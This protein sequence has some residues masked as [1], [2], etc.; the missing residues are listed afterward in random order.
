MVVA[1]VAVFN[2]D[3]VLVLVVL[4]AVVMVEIIRLADQEL[5]TLV[6]AEVVQEHLLLV[7]LVVQVL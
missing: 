4:A 6:E 2:M 7:A 5:L 1:A 3:L